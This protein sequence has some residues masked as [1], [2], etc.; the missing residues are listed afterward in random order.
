MLL[1]K[2]L[3]YYSACYDLINKS[4]Y[5]KINFS[6]STNVSGGMS[7]TDFIKSELQYITLQ[8]RTAAKIKYVPVI[9]IS[10]IITETALFKY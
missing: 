3:E 2:M 6:I 1:K 5:P 4:T 9:K 7:T 10:R 8:H